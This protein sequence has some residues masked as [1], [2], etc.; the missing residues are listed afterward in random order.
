[1]DTSYE[2]VCATLRSAPRRAYLE[3]AHQPEINVIY[4][5]NLDTHKKYSAPKEI[6]N[7]GDECG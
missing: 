4:T 1:M 7:D 3:L 6:K 5:F 2:I